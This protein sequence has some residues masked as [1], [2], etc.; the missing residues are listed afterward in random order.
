[1]KI[2][3]VVVGVIYILVL[4]PLYVSSAFLQLQSAQSNTATVAVVGGSETSLSKSIIDVFSSLDGKIAILL[5]LIA[6]VLVIIGVILFLKIDKPWKGFLVCAG[7]V[8]WVAVEAVCQMV[9]VQLSAAVL[10]P[11]LISSS[12][13]ISHIGGFSLLAAVTILFAV[14]VHYSLSTISRKEIVSEEPV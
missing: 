8:A 1:M 2:V 12:D 3:Y 6:V 11:A 14:A 5:V 13:A 9:G 7:L 4:A 10:I